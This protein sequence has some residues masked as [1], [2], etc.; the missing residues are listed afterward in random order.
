MLMYNERFEC[1][2]HPS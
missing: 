1:G 2:K